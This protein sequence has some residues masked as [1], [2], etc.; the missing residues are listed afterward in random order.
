[1]KKFSIKTEIKKTRNRSLRI[2][3]NYIGKTISIY[4]G[5]KFVNIFIKKEMVGYKLGEF[6]STRKTFKFKKNK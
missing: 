6:S 5:K 3:P 2:I 4:N 1:M